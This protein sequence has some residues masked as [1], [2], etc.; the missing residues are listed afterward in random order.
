MRKLGR[1]RHVT[2]V[3]IMSAAHDLPSTD[4]AAERLLQNQVDIGNA[5]ALTVRKPVS[6]LPPC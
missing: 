4:A 1:P 2:R 6:S 5:I 3:Y